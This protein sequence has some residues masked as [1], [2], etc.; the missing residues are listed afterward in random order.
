MTA[1][2]LVQDTFAIARRRLWV[3]SGEILDGTVRRGQRIIAPAGVDDPV[4][5]VEPILV[6]ATTG[7]SRT[8]LCFEYRDEAAL[9]R[10]RRLAWA[11]VTLE[12]SE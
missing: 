7:E 1:R 3:A 5:A 9:A 6:S 11:G 8:A 12:L 4:S 10:W 2:F